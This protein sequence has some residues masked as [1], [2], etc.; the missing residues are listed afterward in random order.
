MDVTYISKL[1]DF[2]MPCT[3]RRLKLYLFISGFFLLSLGCISVPLSE[4]EESYSV[5]NGSTYTSSPLSPGVVSDGSVLPDFVDVVDSVRGA[6]VSV[7]AETEILSVFG[8][9]FPNFQSGSGVIF[10]EYGHILTNNHV[11]KDATEI[12]VTLDDGRQLNGELVGADP[13]TDLAVIKV[14]SSDLPFLNFASQGEVRVGEWVI[15]IGNALAL[16]GGPSVTVGIVS[17]LGRSLR[18]DRN[19]T[20]YDLIQTDTIINPGNSGGPL[21][22][23]KGEIVG[24]NTAV[25][26]GGQI[27]GIGFAVGGSTATLV[28]KE[29]ID[30]GKV[31]WAWL[32]VTISELDAQEAAK[33]ALPAQKGVLIQ[34]VFSESPAERGGLQAGDVILSVEGH[35]VQTIADLTN[36]LRLE[37]EVGDTVA[38]EVLRDGN[39]NLRHMITLDER[40]SS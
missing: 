1:W 13:L 27:E 36:V 15:A 18:V 35:Y 11:I 7:V 5:T 12:I 20:L 9:I 33:L 28:S 8:E 24:I 16:P 22:N 40:P 21:L 31:R 39:D 2:H 25:L 3:R 37:V 17:A 30:K 38:V 23:L 14:D 10:D 4:T 29:I 32:G 19:T 6:V 34:D 26:R